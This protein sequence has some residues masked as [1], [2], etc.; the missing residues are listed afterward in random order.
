MEAI[1]RLQCPFLCLP[2]LVP[3]TLR[4]LRTLRP[5]CDGTYFRS[6]SVVTR[7]QTHR[8]SHILVR[9]T[10][11]RSM[12]RILTNTCK[13]CTSSTVSVKGAGEE[14]HR[15]PNN[16]TASWHKPHIACCVLHIW[17]N[18]STIWATRICSN[19]S[20]SPA[21]W[22]SIDRP[23]EFIETKHRQFPYGLFTRARRCLPI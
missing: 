18:W 17:N 13:P 14:H 11:T 15:S 12:G 9:S 21:F 20:V 2:K 16:S 6:H 5:T 3:W 8:K 4:R 22:M 23:D 19:A 10:L 1:D 7:K